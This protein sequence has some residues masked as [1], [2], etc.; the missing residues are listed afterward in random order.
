M[1]HAGSFLDH[2]E[3]FTPSSRIYEFLQ[4]QGVRYT[5]I[6][7]P[8]AYT[9]QG[10]ATLAHIPQTQVAKVVI[11]EVDG[12]LAMAVLP[13]DTHINLRRLKA[14]L[15][16]HHVG[17]VTESEFA[18]HFPDCEVGAMP[19]FGNLY[20]MPVYVDEELTADPEIAFNAGAHD[21]VIQLAY[22][23]FARLVSPQVLRFA[24]HPTDVIGW[25]H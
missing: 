23:E 11:V 3:L 24:S 18:R 6:H 14:G 7:H 22:A 10:V 19:P 17:V 20:N 9:A 25:D 4:S 5:T 15:R 16:A 13:A 1:P 2:S 8:P 12:L 21:E